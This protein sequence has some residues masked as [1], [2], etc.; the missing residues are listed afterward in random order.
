M[1]YTIVDLTLQTNRI[2]EPINFKSFFKNRIYKRGDTFILNE[3]KIT[4]VVLENFTESLVIVKN[5][6]IQTVNEKDFQFIIRSACP[7][8]MFGYYNDCEI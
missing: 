3:G 4:L 1:K 7:N 8:N 5:G 2:P 6:E